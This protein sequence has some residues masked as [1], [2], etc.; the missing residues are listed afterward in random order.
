MNMPVI[1]KENY[2]GLD[3]TKFLM[4]LGIIG[5]HSQLPKS[6]LYPYVRLAVPVF[7]LLTGFLR[8]KKYPV[9]KQNR[10]KDRLFCVS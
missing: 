1:E 10:K 7:F 9:K 4:A 2:D 6:M 8:F 5:L 3:I